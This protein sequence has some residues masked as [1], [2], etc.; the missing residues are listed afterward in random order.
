MSDAG[1]DKRFEATPGRRDRARRD[2]NTARSHE[3]AAIAGF[4]AALLGL[5][6]V[7]PLLAGAA[8]AA[9]QTRDPAHA[10]LVVALGFVPAA[11][12]A[13]G[14][15]GAALA[16]SGG[17]RIAGLKLAFDKLA[18]L[19]GL[20]R[21]FG[22]EAAVNGARAIA[23]FVA[24]GGVVAPVALH[25]MGAASA[26]ASPVAAAGIVRAAL[27]QSCFSALAVGALFAF[28]DYA[29]VRGRWL[30]SLK[31]TFDDL[32]RDAKEQDGDP[33][34]KSR[35][36]Q[37]HRTLVRGGVARTHDA[38]FVIVN[39]TH[40]AIAMRYAP[41]A[42]PVPEILV[43]ATDALALDVRALAERAGIPVVE[44]IPLARLLWRSGVAGR[45]I[46]PE[47]FVAVALTIAALMRE[48]VL[49]ANAG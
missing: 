4:A 42:I 15:S 44:D 41:P 11:C 30:H 39:P 45:A 43:R 19:P 46:P 36:K 21:M 35:R 24:V 22:A 8:S 1:G 18:P 10:L 34:A 6:A 5:T 38:S 3:V 17:L 31:M 7:L 16:Q 14:G 12:A 37:L 40:I 25:A 13:T 20:K 32:K 27:L 48:G 28:A 23:A 26:L 2:G 47:T 33:H 49:D 29:V 9:L